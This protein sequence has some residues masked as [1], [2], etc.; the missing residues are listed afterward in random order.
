M[1]QKPIDPTRIILG[2]ENRVYHLGLRSEEIAPLIFTVGD[3]ERV[4]LFKKWFTSI[5]LE[6]VQREFKTITGMRNGKRFSVMSTGMGA[7]NIE[8]VMNE[9][10]L[11][12]NWNLDK[13]ERRIGSLK[14]KIVRIGTSGSIQSSLPVDAI[15]CSTSAF[16]FDAVHYFYPTN[17]S[18]SELSKALSKHLDAWPLPSVFAFD[19]PEA[20]KFMQKAT[21]F[22]EGITY[23]ASGFYS[24]QG[25]FWL[26]DKMPWEN[27]PL[28][29]SQFE[30]QHKKITNIEMETCA[31]YHLGGIFGFETLSLSAIL[32]NR[33]E[34][35]FSTQPEK[36]INKLIENAFDLCL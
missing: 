18:N 32:A 19:N 15:L 13:L 11:L 36:T 7:D 17:L 34:G 27:L 6:R 33:L 22:Y 35:I 4:A 31:I 25:R 28:H 1:Q 14:P 23:S 29:L 24:P 5:E 21:H 9:L 20:K 10:D 16:S 12:F 26:K 30:W 2:K 8:I 3:P